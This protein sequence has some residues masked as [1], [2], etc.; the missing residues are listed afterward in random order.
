MTTGLNLEK[1]FVNDGGADVV[2]ARGA[3]REGGDGVEVRERRGRGEKFVARL[4]YLGADVSEQ[5]HLQ[6]A[7]ALL[8][9]E[10]ERFILLQLKRDEALRLR[11]RLLARV[12][13]GNEMQ[14]RSRD[15]DEVAEDLV[16]AD[17]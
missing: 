16:V 13:S 2:P 3:L 1:F 11:E 17:A 7:D 10:H 4:A 6:L 14:V 12:G 9:V 5:T 15:L 8:R